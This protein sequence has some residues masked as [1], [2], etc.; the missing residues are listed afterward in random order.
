M[1]PG[2]RRLA[3]AG[4]LGCAAGAWLLA[5]IHGGARGRPVD[6]CIVDA[7]QSITAV[8]GGWER[9]A[10]DALAGAARAAREDG[11][12]LLVVRFGADLTRLFG[13]GD[14]AGFEAAAT[15][16][17]G[18]DGSRS[19]LR[20]A[21]ALARELTR[22]RAVARLVLLSD[23]SFTGPRPEPE[24]ASL[25]AGATVEWRDPPA[26]D[27]EDAAVSALRLPPD[28][29]PGAPLA[30]VVEGRR[31]PASGAAA[32][33]ALSVEVADAAGVRVFERRVD[34][35]P[36]PAAWPLGD[37]P[38]VARFELGV[39]SPG[40][41]R[42][43]ARV[44]LAGDP[45]P[46]DD[47]ARAVVVA[48]AE[49]VGLVCVAPEL[50]ADAE[51]ERWLGA[52]GELAGLRLTR[53]VPAELAGLL[54]HA[55][56]LVTLD[57]SE[58][59][60]DAAALAAFVERG[61]GWLELGGFALLAGQ[62]GPLTPLVATSSAHPP[63]R[64]ML[65]VDGSGSMSGAPFAALRA[66][67][68][69]LLALAPAGAEFELAFFTDHLEA[70][71][72]LPV[73]DPA[74][75]ARTLLAA[76]L[77]GGPTSLART[78]EDL[79]ARVAGTRRDT[80]A[81]LLSD[82]RDPPADASALDRA[83]DLRTRLAAAGCELVPIAMGPDADAEGLRAWA[84]PDAEVL[85]P[86]DGAALFRALRDE[87]A[88]DWAREERGLAV[89]VAAPAVS[90]P[91]RELQAVFAAGELP[92]VDRLLHARPARSTVD[93][94]LETADGEPVLVLESRGA[95]AVAAAATLPA[96]GWAPA[97]SRRAAS[98]APLLR[99]LARGGPGAANA[100]RA[101]VED[102]RLVLERVPADWPPRVW[103]RLAG[104]AVALDVPATAAGR[105]PLTVRAGAL[106][107]G[108]LGAPAP[109]AL[110]LAEGAAAG[111]PPLA[112][113][114]LAAPADEETAFP[115]RRVDRGGP[116]AASPAP[117]PA[118][119][120]HPAGPAVLACGLACL[121]AAALRGWDR[122]SR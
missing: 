34:P 50:E 22:D 76:R 84:A 101:A 65:L 103:A 1:I 95:G 36:S 17:A 37:R 53:A 6:V 32:A 51:L 13:P 45:L 81:F 75:A 107:Q 20:A 15:D 3:L 77:P 109:A 71:H 55:D 78:A 18:G 9:W 100:P 85:R 117:P 10:R 106:P 110:E 19:E 25:A 41:S 105:D 91:A 46:A 12:E 7:S 56:L 66:A 40:L 102:G 2:A 119:R 24:L 82:G 8:R 72:P 47:V 60:L 114:A 59:R 28:P 30:C 112:R 86:D 96:A 92:P 42:V 122:P 111:G 87:V 29:E 69:R 113:V 58:A 26:P 27:R 62:P 5:P 35:A 31:F 89:R 104:T 39:T 43:T 118:R 80:L 14:P 52:L 33:I 64:V 74:A 88:G 93:V 21:L 121:A 108:A 68:R 116:E 49:R 54:P 16:L 83:R 61:G 11:R 99:A 38:W 90:G 48:G 23:G 79:L 63:R 120:G 98:L 4:A 115:P 70:D 44:R 57:L 67:V 94:L 97:W 73:G